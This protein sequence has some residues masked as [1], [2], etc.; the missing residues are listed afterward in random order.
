[1]DPVDVLYELKQRGDAQNAQMLV[2]ERGQVLGTLKAG[3]SPLGLSGCIGP[4]TDDGGLIV[5][6][7]HDPDASG[8]PSGVLLAGQ[9]E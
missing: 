7:G 5:L 2:G 1:M 3:N 9:G 8:L 6:I 4:H